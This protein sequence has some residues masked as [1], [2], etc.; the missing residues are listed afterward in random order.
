MEA[1]RPAGRGR[2]RAA[3]GYVAGLRLSLSLGATPRPDLL[4]L[5][6]AC[7]KAQHASSRGRDS[8]SAALRR[9][10]PQEERASAGFVGCCCTAHARC[11]CRQLT[12]DVLD[13]MEVLLDVVVRLGLQPP[14]RVQASGFRVQPTHSP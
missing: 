9:D 13:E 7:R 11:R 4:A 12:L 14:A 10:A 3:A 1:G 5:P 8:L 2:G 6:A